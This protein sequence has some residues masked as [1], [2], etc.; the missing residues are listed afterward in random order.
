MREAAEQAEQAEQWS[1]RFFPCSNMF[2]QLLQGSAKLPGPVQGPHGPYFQLL[3]STNPGRHSC[4]RHA[5]KRIHLRM[6]WTPLFAA[7]KDEPSF[8]R[9]EKT[10]SAKLDRAHRVLA[11]VSRGL[12]TFRFEVCQH[13]KHGK[14]EAS[15]H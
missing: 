7:G 12:S 8:G 9:R 2:Q 4:A 3:L 11:D 10:T 13:C 6:S 15:E 14:A 5:V 1:G